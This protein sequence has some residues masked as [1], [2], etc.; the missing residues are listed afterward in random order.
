MPPYVI[1]RDKQNF[2]PDPDRFWPE[3]WLA[4]DSKVVTNQ[5][6][7][8]PVLLGPMNCVDKSLA[9]LELQVVVATLVQQFNMDLKPE[10]DPSNWEKDLEDYFIFVKGKLLVVLSTREH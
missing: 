3:R 5:A 6:V 8:L 1:H 9:Q 2:S 4:T 7:F 10:W